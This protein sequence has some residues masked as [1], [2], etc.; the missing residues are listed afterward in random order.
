M[1]AEHEQAQHHAFALITKGAQRIEQTVQVASDAIRHLASLRERAA[2]DLKEQRGVLAGQ[3]RRLGASLQQTSDQLTR[4]DRLAQEVL[5]GV[6]ERLRRTAGYIDTARREDI[7]H[8]LRAFASRQ[9]A[10]FVGGAL[11]LGLALGRLAKSSPAATP[12]Q[13][14]RS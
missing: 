8:D 10:M 7:V 13:E 9:P 6:G 2:D 4:E 5:D 11:L 3:V 12:G 14:G 1:P